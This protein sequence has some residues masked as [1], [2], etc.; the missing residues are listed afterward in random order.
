RRAQE[1][2][3]DLNDP[4]TN[5]RFAVVL[6]DFWMGWGYSQENRKCLTKALE[7]GDALKHTV[8]YGQALREA[9][10]TAMKLFDNAAAAGLIEQ[11]LR[12]AEM[13]SDGKDAGLAHSILGGLA[14]R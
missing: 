1:I 5:L 7:Q 3:A 4:E 8:L 9:G 10:V 14:E 2:A 6:S 12:I 13:H 11:S